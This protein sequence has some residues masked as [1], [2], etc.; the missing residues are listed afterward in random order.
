MPSRFCPRRRALS[1]ALTV[2]LLLAPIGSAVAQNW[3]QWRGPHGNSTSDETGLSVAWTEDLGIAWKTPLPEW[4][5]STPAIWGDAVFVTT[6]HDDDLLVLKLNRSTGQI[7]WTQKVGE[8][9]TPRTGPK[10]EK[11]KFHQLHNLASPSP[12]ADGEFV[13]VHFGNGDLAVYDYDGRQ[14]WR[15]NL[16]DDYGTYTI[17]WGH[18]NSPLLYRGLVISVNMQDSL[19]DLGSKQAISYLV[20]HDLRS[21]KEI[22]KSERMTGAKSEE[23]DAYTTPVLFDAGGQQQLVVM[24][25]NQLDAYDPRTGKQLWYLPGLVGG[26][27]VTGPTVSDGMIYVTRGMRGALLAIRPSG[28]GQRPASDIVWKQ[29]QGTP[30]TPCPVVW[31]ELLF[32]ITDDGIGRTYD[33]PARPRRGPATAQG[34]LQSLAAGRRRPHLLSQHR[35]A[36]HRAHGRRARREAG[37]EQAGRQH[38]GFAG[39]RRQA[40]IHPRP[41]RLV[42]HR[43]CRRRREP[44]KRIV[45][46]TDVHLNFL[47]AAQVD[48]FLV[49]VVAERPDAVLIGGDIA[50][51]DNVCEYLARMHAAARRRAD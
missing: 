2:I 47:P 27:T 25:G 35:G 11:Q 7:E 45:W 22:W 15:R 40:L 4:G 29:E 23:G 9:S 20:A 26:R 46:L 16:Q 14:Q 38:A 37:R 42:L 39:S 24:G 43:A 34:Q 19:A 30:D 17:W 48:A 12:V 36:V 5:T 18:A 3:P 41:A 6:Q 44:M 8:A 51:S 13:V 49:R 31:H 10:R 1:A 21:G 33:A 32:T 28:K 50:E